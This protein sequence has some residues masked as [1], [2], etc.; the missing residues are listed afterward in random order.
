MYVFENNGDPCI[1][2]AANAD[3]YEKPDH[4]DRYPIVHAIVLNKEV[5]G[6]IRQVIE[7][8]KLRQYKDEDGFLEKQEQLADK[9][10]HELI[11]AVRDDGR[12]PQVVF[13]INE[14]YM[15][16]LDIGERGHHNWMLLPLIDLRKGET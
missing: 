7:F 13:K 16:L 5:Y 14:D 11:K 10:V 12:F 1:Y 4:P 15:K 2:T 9:M 6:V 8:L 3:I